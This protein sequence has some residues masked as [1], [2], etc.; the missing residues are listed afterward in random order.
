MGMIVSLH[1]VLQVTKLLLQLLDLLFQLL[2][3]LFGI[4]VLVINSLIR[5]LS[6]LVIANCKLHL[7]FL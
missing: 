7:L 2:D 3:T 5:H 1:L 4:C 6:L